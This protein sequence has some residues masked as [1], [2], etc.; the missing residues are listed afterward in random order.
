ML[1]GISINCHSSIKFDKEKVIYFDP[2]KIDKEVHDADII[3]ITHSH[4]DHF[5]L[6][7]IKNIV[8]DSTIFVLPKS[9]ESESSHLFNYQIIFVEP[10]EEYRVSFLSFSTVPSYNINKEFHP[11][12]NG[13]VGYIIIINDI[14]YYIA[15]DTDDLEE[16][17]DIDVDVMFVPIGGTY[18]MDFI[19]ASHFVNQVKPKVVIPTHYGLLVGTR[20][21]G[22]KFKLLIDPTIECRLLI[23]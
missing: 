13:W 3:F 17:C 18:T 11:K 1:D 23:N 22:E 7:S 20:Q 8:K 10:N 9:M 2:Y 21:D 19:E 16:N 6:D 5:D 14:K 12:E 15:G 4:Y